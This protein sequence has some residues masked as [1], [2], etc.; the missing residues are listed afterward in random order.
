[1][2]DYIDHFSIESYGDLDLFF[3]LRNP[4]LGHL[5]HLT[6]GIGIC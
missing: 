5:G 6:P 1:M 2:Q 4:H 3:M